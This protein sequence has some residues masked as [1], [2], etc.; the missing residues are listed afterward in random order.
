M[1]IY[2]YK[3]CSTN[4][5]KQS[6][7]RQLFGKTFDRVVIEY[8]SG[9]NEKGRPLFQ[10]LKG[11]LVRGDEIHFNDLSRAGRNTK[12]LLSTVEDLVERGIKVVFHAENLTF[13]DVEQDPMVGAMS[14]MLLT[15]LSSVNELFLTQ[16]KIA[17]KQG[18]QNAKANG[19]K[20]GGSSPKWR[21]TYNNN[22]EQGLHT[23]TK[24]FKDSPEKE[25]TVVAVK[26][27][28]SYSSYQKLE[29]V[30][31]V[32]NKNGVTT[33]TGKP[34]SKTNLYNFCNRNNIEWRKGV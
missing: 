7:D 25:K 19:K 18:L 20:I 13:V 11:K 24:L 32:L 2:A 14:K 33:A 5:D 23:T 8:A 16:T 3:R 15:M 34:W 21:E 22:R 4:E 28:L 12:E 9:K 17:V 1:T 30:A 31:D 27:A 29:E 6:V 10:E 26:T